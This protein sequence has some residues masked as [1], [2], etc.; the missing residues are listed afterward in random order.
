MGV[1]NF[2]IFGLQMVLSF[3]VY[4]L[5]ARWYVAPWLAR[6]PFHE[7]FIPL[8]LVHALRHLGVTI[9]V[10][11]VT[12]PDLPRAWAAQ[13]AYGDL[14]AA[15][16]ALLSILA[17]RARASFAV[18][19]VWIFNL[20]GTLDLVN[21]L[22]QGLRLGATEFEVGSFWYVPTFIVPALFVT[23]FMMFAMLVRGPREARARR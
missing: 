12:S 4:G 9:L 5:I 21:A 18:A 13:V 20:E 15:L 7:A 3:V 8:L 11:T 6:F 17:L 10:P 23:H 2:E 22:Y 14:L 19:L 1:G 16:I